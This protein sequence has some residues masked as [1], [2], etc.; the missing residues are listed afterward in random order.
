M[1]SIA[2]KIIFGLAGVTWL[3]SALAQNYSLDWFSLDGGGGT[4]AGG[5]YALSG[6]IGEA[7][8]GEMAGGSYSLM[9]GFWSILSES[10]PLP[11]LKISVTSTNTVL[12]I[13]PS[14]AIGFVLEQNS[15]L[16]P[17]NWAS[18]TEVPIDD[19]TT[20]SVVLDPGAGNRF[21]RLRK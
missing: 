13:W 4:S 12:V 11:R 16:L 14:S 19:A 17:D 9:G 5:N 6:T 15:T 21:L 1:I 10:Q 8:A 7:D 2:R 3:G 18:V 20:K